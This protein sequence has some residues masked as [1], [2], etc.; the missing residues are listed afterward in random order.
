M[1]SL[2]PDSEKFNFSRD[3]NGFS[4]DDYVDAIDIDDN[5][6]NMWKCT[7]NGKKFTIYAPNYDTAKVRAKERCLDNANT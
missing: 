2:I 1:G 7:C 6:N 3:A 5:G 4:L